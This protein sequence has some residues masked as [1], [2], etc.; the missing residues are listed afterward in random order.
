MRTLSLAELQALEPIKQ[1]VLD[2]MQAIDDA[3]VGRYFDA[4]PDIEEH[5]M[6]CIDS[7]CIERIERVL[8]QLQRI[9][10]A[11]Q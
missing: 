2:T 11:V 4:N 3:T 7:N 10:K 8:G 9:L 1:R 6:D 5:A